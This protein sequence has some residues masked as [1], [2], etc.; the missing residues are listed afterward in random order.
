MEAAKKASKQRF[1]LKDLLNVPMQRIL[2]YPLLLKELIKHTPEAHPD[3]SKLI[4]AREEVE[5]LAKY[6]N[7]TKK[8]FDN[9]KKMVASL[10]GYTGARPL[11]EYGAL[12]KD[13][14]LMFKHEQG[15]EKL[16]LRYV[17]MFSN[18]IILT[19]EKGPTFTYK[20]LVEFAENQEVVDMPF[21]TL[22]KD[23]QDGKVS[24]QAVLCAYSPRTHTATPA[25][26]RS[27]L[28]P[29]RSRRWTARARSSRHMCLRPS[30]CRPRRS[31]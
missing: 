14:D 4:I 15:K 29:G 23:E 18:A 25:H 20:S 5:A 30:P 31:G 6:I 22:P 11:S 1:P 8:D 13:G 2:K 16:K 3:K 9:M 19:K 10:K 7:D 26:P 21:W 12:V 28:T 27:T 17:F 24:L